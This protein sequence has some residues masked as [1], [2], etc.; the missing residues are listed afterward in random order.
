MKTVI[1]SKATRAGIKFVAGVVGKRNSLP[2][3]SNVHLYANGCFQ[4]TGTDLDVTLT[5]RLPGATEVE[6]KTTL[7]ARA[8]M[9]AVAGGNDITLETDDKNVTTFLTG[10][11]H[12]SVFGLAADIFPP[13]LTAPDSAAKVTV[14]AGLFI[15]CLKQVEM[16]MST[17][18]S[19]YVLNGVC[20]DIS[21]EEIKFIATDGRRLQT[22]LLRTGGAPLTAEEKTAVEVAQKALDDAGGKLD[23]AQKRF[24]AGLA[25]NPPTYTAIEVAP[26]G[27]LYRKEDHCTVRCLQAVL[28]DCKTSVTAAKVELNKLNAGRILILPVKAV[29]HLVRLPLDKKN[30]GTLTLSDWT[31]GK[32]NTPYA[33]VD[34]G[35]YSIVTKLI[36]GNYP[37]YRQVIPT[38]S[39][40]SVPVNIAD[41]RP[42]L[43]IAEKATSE[44]ANSVKLIFTKY[45]LEITAN[46][47][48]I[49][50]ASVM[51]PCGYNEVNPDGSELVFTTAFNPRY[52]IEAC[53]SLESAGETMT[54][55]FIDELSPVKITNGQSNLVVIMP[56][57][58][59]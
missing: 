9:D 47:P 36:E 5:A 3:L 1:N 18:E 11:S 59:N 38:E 16:A 8:L 25:A 22:A 13:V 51:V 43:A 15:A 37:N 55:H 30:P 26:Y 48:E 40:I 44:K 57:R 46:S 50:T 21:A 20:L 4:V 45:N 34:C 24:D 23:D 2:I 14:P 27:T 35:D 58:L 31:F 53:D 56:M 52:L 6:G 28:D 39:R 42:A 12:R 32:E 29:R 10:T 33:S 49:G 41:L 17:D 54:L 19:R 7:P